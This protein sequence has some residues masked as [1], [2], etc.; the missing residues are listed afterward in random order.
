MI[1]G[2]LCS[3]GFGSNRRYLNLTISY[4]VEI[5]ISMGVFF[6]KEGAGLAGRDY[7]RNNEQNLCSFTSPDLSISNANSFLKIIE[8]DIKAFHLSLSRNQ[9]SLFFFTS[10]HWQSRSQTSIDRK[11]KSKKSTRP[12]TIQNCATRTPK[13]P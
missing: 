5:S 2:L 6:L 11:P 8:P 4:L 13:P 9:V 1:P 10:C 12:P 7:S 3:G